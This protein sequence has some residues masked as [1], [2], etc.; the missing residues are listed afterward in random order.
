MY[1]NQSVA[2][3]DGCFGRDV[4][5]KLNPRYGVKW[6]PE[7]RLNQSEISKHGHKIGVLK[8]R[9]PM[10]GS[11]NGRYGSKTSTFKTEDGTVVYTSKDDPRVVSGELVGISK[12]M[13]LPNMGLTKRKN[14]D[15]KKFLY[16]ILED[17][18][19][20]IIELSSFEYVQWFTS[21]KLKTCDLIKFPEKY[22][23][24]YRLKEYKI[25]PECKVVQPIKKP[26]YKGITLKS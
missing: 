20:N 3:K 25:N 4:S 23:K 5:G 26:K 21:M 2:A 11:A 9:P 7:Q 19:K 18:D 13:K 15:I 22:H 16:F 1:V 24:G 6:T 8:P 10:I 14:P 17:E 12:G